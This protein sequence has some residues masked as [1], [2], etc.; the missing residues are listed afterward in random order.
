[1]PKARKAFRY[2]PKEKQ[3]GDSIESPLTSK[4]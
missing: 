1:M 3:K 2:E 4:V